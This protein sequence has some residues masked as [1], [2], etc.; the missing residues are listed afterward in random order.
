MK[1]YPLQFGERFGRLT[2]RSEGIPTAHHRR[3]ICRCDCGSIKTVHLN[4]LRRGATRSCGCLRLETNRRHGMHKT[5]EYRVWAGMLDRCT[6][7][8][9]RCWR[10][11]GGRGIV[12]CQR[13]RQSFEA[14]LQD[15]GRRPSPVHSIDRFPNNNGNYEPGNV[16]WAT[17]REQRLNK[18]AVIWERIV[19]LLAEQVGVS[20]EDVRK[21]IAGGSSDIEIA[22]WIA[23]CFKPD[24]PTHIS[25]SE[26]TS[27]DHECRIE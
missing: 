3:V 18:R 26:T 9:S 2:V 25:V 10:N 1:K 12:V 17:G 21:R 13:W 7:S 11:Y 23:V 16:R 6:N 27:G 20:P 24:Q 22:L 14:F 15:V 8:K 5:P 4:A 19:L